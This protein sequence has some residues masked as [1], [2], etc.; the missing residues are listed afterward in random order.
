V[1]SIFQRS[2]RVNNILQFRREITQKKDEY[3][4]GLNQQ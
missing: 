3:H 2:V 4:I 1:F